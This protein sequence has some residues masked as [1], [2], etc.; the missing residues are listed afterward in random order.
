MKKIIQLEEVAMLGVSM[1]ALYY[2]KVEWWFYLLLFL[3]PDISMLGYLAGNKPGALIY[4]I[5]HHKGLAILIFIIGFFIHSWLLQVVGI[6]LFGHSAMDRVFGY[7]L[8]YFKGFHYTH[9][10]QIGQ[11]KTI[12]D[13]NIN[14]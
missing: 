9:L 10:G 14:Y 8:K 7:G 6:I 1:Y 13:N 5:F 2:L 4:N 12:S 3:G 11:S